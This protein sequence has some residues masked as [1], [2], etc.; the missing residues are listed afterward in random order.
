MSDLHQSAIDWL[1]TSSANALFASFSTSNIFYLLPLGKDL[2]DKP[3]RQAQSMG[4]LFDGVLA[5]RHTTSLGS[6]YVR[7]TFGL[8]KE[9]RND[10]DDP[11]RVIDAEFLFPEGALIGWIASV[12]HRAWD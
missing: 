9:G 10:V 2:P 3:K 7:V 4:A 6:E 8:P 5:D 1:F 12:K 11:T